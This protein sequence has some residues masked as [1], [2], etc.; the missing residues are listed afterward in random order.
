MSNNISETCT[1]EE[2]KDKMDNSLVVETIEGSIIMEIERLDLAPGEV[3]PELVHRELSRQHAVI[4]THSAVVSH[5]SSF[6]DEV[7]RGVYQV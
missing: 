2:E 4:S 3:A 7:L 6:I 5:E 1:S